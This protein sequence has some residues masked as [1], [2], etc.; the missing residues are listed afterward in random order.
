MPPEGLERFVQAQAPVI[1]TVIE[2]LHGGRKD[3]HWMWFVFP[4]LHG[5]GHSRKAQLYGIVNMDEARDYLDH[6]LLGPR[7]KECFEMVLKHQDRHVEDIF[8][9]VDAMKFRS[10]ATLFD[11][12]SSVPDNVFR[13]ALSVFFGGKTDPET[14]RL[15]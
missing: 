4:Q 1:A 8:G 9:H 14:L 7:L 2:E 13:Q 6:P 5:L 3:T 11:R 12:A 10:S 15:L